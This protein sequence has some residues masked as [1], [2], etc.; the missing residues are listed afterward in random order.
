MHFPS[1]NLAL[2]LINQQAFPT[3]QL[4]SVSL[5]ICSMC[6]HSSSIQK[7]RM[8]LPSVVKGHT[9]LL[10]NIMECLHAYKHIDTRQSPSW[11]PYTKPL[12]D[13]TNS[14]SPTQE[15]SLALSL[16]WFLHSNYFLFSLHCHSRY[17]CASLVAWWLSII[18]YNRS[19]SYLP[20]S[21]QLIETM[22]DL[23]VHCSR[24][25]DIF[26]RD[27]EKEMHFTLRSSTSRNTCTH[28]DTFVCTTETTV[29]PNFTYPIYTWNVYFC[30]SHQNPLIWFRTYYVTHFDNIFISSKYRVSYLMSISAEWMNKPPKKNR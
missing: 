16:C 5:L 23:Y 21:S 12:S 27:P 10:W 26:D 9:R 19:Y 22:T 11:L 20:V 8:T 17:L 4:Y 30:W 13:V 3:P 6:S 14:S 7:P 2:F 29:F 28:T 25:S 24:C 1:L 15:S 18:P